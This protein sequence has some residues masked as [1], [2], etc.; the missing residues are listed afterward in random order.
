MI[1]S[2][3]V[4][5]LLPVVK[6][7]VEELLKRCKNEGLNVKI[8]QTLR[9]NEYQNF[10]YA[11]GRTIKGKI[12]TNAIGGESFHNYGLAFD[13]CKNL[14]GHEYDNLEFFRKAGEIWTE[15]GGTWGGNFINFAD[16]PHFEFSKLITIEELKIGKRLDENVKMD[17][18]NTV[19]SKNRFLINGEIKEL[20][21]IIYNNRNYIE[22]R[23]LSN[24]GFDITY[25]NERKL[26]IINLKGCK[27]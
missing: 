15:M 5:D 21:S 11:Q 3:N 12:V 17:W 26:P 25:D 9:D 2:R 24:L 7:G 22:L 27:Y 8:T 13:I 19:V 1:N 4:D 14:V 16:R 23:E 10:L 18:E 6:R 20:N